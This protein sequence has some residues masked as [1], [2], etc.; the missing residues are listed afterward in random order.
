LLHV[1]TPIGGMANFDVQ[2]SVND[3]EYQP[4]TSAAIE[5]ISDVVEVVG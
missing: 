1:Y 3:V 5:G 4:E 2:N